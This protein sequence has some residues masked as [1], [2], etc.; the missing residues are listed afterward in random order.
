M[1]GDGFSRRTFLYATVAA[2]TATAV[3][4]GARA[5]EAAVPGFY[6][7]FSGYPITGTWQ[8]HLNQVRPWRSTARAGDIYAARRVTDARSIDRTRP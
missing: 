7:P 1:A 2:G 6:N 3:S 4:I 5:A 8:E